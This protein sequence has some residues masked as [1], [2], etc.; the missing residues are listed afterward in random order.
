MARYLLLGSI[1]ILGLGLFALGTERGPI[2][3]LSDSDFTSENGVIAGTGTPDDPYIIAGWDIQVPEGGLY[4]VRIENT[5]SC[6]ILRG[7]KVLGARDPDGAGIYL[8]DVE[9]G[10]IEDCLVQNSHNGIVLLGSHGIA[11]R[12]TYMFVAGLGLQVMG[13]SPEHYQHVIERTNLVNGKPVHYYYGLEDQ[14]LEGIEAGHITLAGCRQVTLKGA[15]VEEGDGVTVAFSEDMVVEGADLFH[16]RG[17]GLF[18]LSSPRTVVRDCERIANN[19]LSGVSVWLSPRSQV[20]HNGIY[21]NQVGL[22]INA[23]DRVTCVENAYGGNAL[24]LLVTGA[25]REVEIRDSL[26]SQNK[27]SIQLDFAI[28]AVIERCAITDSDIGVQ[29]DAPSTYPRV[30]DCSFIQVGYGLDILGSQG[31]FEGNL[32]AYANI[33]IIFEEAYGETHPTSNT[34]RHNLI[35]RSR[36]GLYLGHESTDTWIY[37]NLI[38]DCD[39]AARDFGKNRWAPSGRGN[40]YSDYHGSDA[41]ADGIG[42]API[43][44]GG[45]GVD[46]APV[47]ARSFVS[48]L[49]GVL[50][51]MEQGQVTLVDE[52]G[53]S[54]SLDVLIADQAHERLLGFQGVP[55]EL[56]QDMAILFVWDEAGNYGF[57]N[58]GVT[59]N[60]DVLF[61]AE[62]GS[63]A[64]DLTMPAGSEDRYAARNP[65]M[66]ALEV[67]EGRLRELGLGKPVR[68]LLP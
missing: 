36:D 3:I 46:P 49:P 27:T 10:T 44:F 11:I 4:G 63:F 1:A 53:T 19:A 59:I 32:I 12:D 66:Y 9:N 52:A 38:W 18:V 65:F 34:L 7:V 67:P 2:T 17:H 57:W 68:L 8:A 56:A 30:R 26:F 47:M 62:D 5:D 31:T 40:W 48:E 14:V 51:T 50:S 41:D 55:K 58:R 37:E 16:N 23:S 29:V 13:T 43:Q 25:A 20:V 64:G 42:D 28:G 22:Y 24:G 61:F 21:G 60:L 54:L 35:F 33:G 6:F 39:R 45:G 15:R